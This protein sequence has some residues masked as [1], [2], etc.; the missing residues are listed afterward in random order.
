MPDSSELC[1]AHHKGRR[2]CPTR[3][4]SPRIVPDRLVR[5]QTI[6]LHR[7][8]RP[9][10]RKPPTI[11]LVQKTAIKIADHLSL[12]SQKGY[13]SL[14]LFGLL[15]PNLLLAL[16]R[17]RHKRGKLNSHLM[18]LSVIKYLMSYLSMVTIDCHIQ[19]LRL[20]N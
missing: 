11:G 4:D 1:R 3:P 14:S 18:L 2:H 6:R 9:E 17:T 10:H 15:R 16:T 12:R 13:T 19:F 8:D 5:S 20:K 7:S